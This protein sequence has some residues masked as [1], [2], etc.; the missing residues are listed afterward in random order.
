MIRFLDVVDPSINNDKYSSTEF[1]II[2]GVL[3]LL[4]IIFG[5]LAVLKTKKSK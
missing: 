3:A 4:V 2:I 5:T 1:Y